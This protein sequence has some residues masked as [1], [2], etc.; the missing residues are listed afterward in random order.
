MAFC[1]LQDALACLL[2][3]AVYQIRSYQEQHGCHVNKRRE[4]SVMKKVLGVILLGAFTSTIVLQD[5]ALAADKRAQYTLAVLMFDT[6]GRLS[7]SEAALLTE[8][9]QS[10]LQRTGVFEL[11]D[12]ASVAATLARV[13]FS[14]VGC[15]DLDC[16]VQAGRNLGAQV[17]V[18][19]S[20]RKSGSLYFID[21]NMVHVGSGQAVNS[22]KED[23]EGDFNRLK[24]YMATVAR[25]LVG[26]PTAGEMQSVSRREA[27]EADV[28]GGMIGINED[29]GGGTNFLMIG[30]IAAGAVGAGVLISKAANKNNENNGNGNG[31][32]LPRP[33][34]FP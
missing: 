7:D 25:K 5:L 23:F 16:A 29:N 15:S 1:R 34:N 17:V 24:N 19:G 10:E 13:S 20:V 30:L 22:I 18:N 12:R 14:E 6:N 26:V 9:L 28:S 27:A 3:H 32:G 11:M 21:V 8:R 4:S 31:T 33:P 2:L